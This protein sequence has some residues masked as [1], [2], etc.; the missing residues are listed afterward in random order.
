TTINRRMNQL[1]SITGSRPSNP[2]SP[3][4]QTTDAGRGIIGPPPVGLT[5]PP[6]Q[7]GPVID[8]P[9]IIQ[10]PDPPPPDGPGHDKVRIR[11]DTPMFS[12]TNPEGWIFRMQAYFDY[13]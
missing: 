3:E 1:Y 8:E 6:R 7:P 10:V 2:N 12:G 9:P 4:T 13:Y 5:Q 11:L